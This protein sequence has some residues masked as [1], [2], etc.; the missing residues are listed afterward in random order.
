MKP[1]PEVEPRNFDLHDQHFAI[2][3]IYSGRQ[4]LSLL[5]EP[6]RQT[7]MVYHVNSSTK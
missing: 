3:I 1:R 5:R 7:H 6:I 2:K 4:K